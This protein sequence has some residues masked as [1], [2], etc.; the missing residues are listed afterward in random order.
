MV[1]NLRVDPVRIIQEI[2]EKNNLLLAPKKKK[3]R[4]VIAFGIVENGD[5]YSIQL[6]KIQY[7]ILFLF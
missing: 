3:K 5:L 4:L 1:Q 2:N 7:E 6:I